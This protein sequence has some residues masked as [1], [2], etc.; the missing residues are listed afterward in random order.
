MLKSLIPRI[1]LESTPRSANEPG[2]VDESDRGSSQT[3]RNPR[4]R[5]AIDGQ[6]V[7]LVPQT[8]PKRGRIVRRLSSRSTRE[9]RRAVSAV[10]RK[11]LVR[12]EMHGKQVPL[13]PR[14]F[15]RRGR[16]IRKLP[17]RE[18]RR[19][20]LAT[21]RK[22]LIRLAMHGRRGPLIIRALSKKRSIVRRL[23]SGFTS[24]RS[25]LEHSDSISKPRIRRKDVV[26][27]RIREVVIRDRPEKSD[28][29]SRRIVRRLPSRPLIRR[30]QAVLANRS[31]LKHSKTSR[32]PRIRAAID[33]QQVPLVPRTLPEKGEIIPKPRIQVAIDGQQVPLIP[34]TLPEK[35]LVRRHSTPDDRVTRRL[36]AISTAKDLPSESNLGD[37]AAAETKSAAIRKIRIECEK[38]GNSTTHKDTPRPVVENSQKEKAFKIAIARFRRFLAEKLGARVRL[39]P[40]LVIKKH[41]VGNTVVTNSQKAREFLA[42]KLGARVRLA[43]SIVINKHLVAPSTVINKHPVA[44]KLL[45]ED[46]IDGVRTILRSRRIVQRSRN[47]VLQT[48][49]PGILVAEGDASRLVRT[50]GTPLSERSTDA[51]GMQSKRNDEVSED[52]LMS[53]LDEFENLFPSKPPVISAETGDLMSTT[54]SPF[55]YLHSAPKYPEYRRLLLGGSRAS[56]LDVSQR[57]FS[58]GATSRPYATAA[59]SER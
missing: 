23:P 54:H 34:P 48:K 8:P 18:R 13:V 38:S 47:E 57:L 21:V 3:V 27:V 2:S 44:P 35:G 52:E 9:K 49:G 37:N 55:R 10:V 20:V 11:P 22:P 36:R 31:V 32:M 58:T 45:F 56:N 41:V 4:I 14:T 59:V 29:R 50:I 43:P 39:A 33:G 1:R 24:E 15:P 42:E 53:L 46:Y 5:V 17:T 25:V 30:R 16:I 40:N 51:R 6:Q 26:K 7:P 19:A 28:A 12:V